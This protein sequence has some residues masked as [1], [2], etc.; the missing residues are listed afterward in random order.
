MELLNL[1]TTCKT[2]FGSLEVFLTIHI[3][4]NQGQ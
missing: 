1:Y 2:L 3:Q 4:K